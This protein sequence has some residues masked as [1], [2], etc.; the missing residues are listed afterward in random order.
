[1]CDSFCQVLG[2]HNNKMCYLI[3]KIGTRSGV[4][5]ML[6]LTIWF[7]A[8]WNWFVGESGREGEGSP[9]SCKQ[10]FMAISGRGFKDK[11]ARKNMSSRG[12]VHKVP[13]KK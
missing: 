7:I 12:P 8:F 9:E 13:G 2:K 11:N 10:Y 4:D 5:V 6:N 1:M 3:Q